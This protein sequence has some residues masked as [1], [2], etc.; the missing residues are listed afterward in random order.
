MQWGWI[1]QPISP[2]CAIRSNGVFR[3]RENSIHW[4]CLSA[5]PRSIVESIIGPTQR[6][7][8]KVRS[9]VP[10]AKVIGFPRGITN[11]TAATKAVRVF[12][13]RVSLSVGWIS[14]AQ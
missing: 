5:A 10:G 7:I 1:G 12:V 14:C 11:V 9:H 4:R 3:C 2:S 13:I 8:A 6:I